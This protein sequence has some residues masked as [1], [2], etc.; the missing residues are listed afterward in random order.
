MLKPIRDHVVLKLIEEKAESAGGIVRPIKAIEEP[1]RGVVVNVNETYT[2]PDGSSKKAEVIV[3]D[4]V[5][6]GKTHGT[7][8]IDRKGEK[9]LLISEEFLI[10]KE[11]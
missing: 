4:I 11:G 6:Y 5:Y 7:E 10:C 8:I 3:G 2:M 9:F 1:Y